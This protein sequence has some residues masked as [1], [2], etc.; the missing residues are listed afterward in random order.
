MLFQ[1]EKVQLDDISIISEAAMNDYIVIDNEPFYPFTVDWYNIRNYS[2]I[3]NIQ[4]MQKET[5]SNADE[6]ITK[7][8]LRKGEIIK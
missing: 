6:L 5:R 3:I 2:I 1:H 4:I 8:Q 7:L